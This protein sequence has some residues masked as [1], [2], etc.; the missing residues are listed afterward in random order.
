MNHTIQRTIGGL[1]LIGSRS[2]SAIKGHVL[3][4]I[5]V[6]QKKSTDKKVVLYRRKRKIPLLP[7]L[8]NV[9]HTT[10]DERQH[11]LCMTQL[12]QKLEKIKAQY[13]RVLNRKPKPHKFGVGYPVPYT[14]IGRARTR[15]DDEETVDEYW[16]GKGMNSLIL[17]S[18]A[19][20]I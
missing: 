1:V 8:N 13:Q 10:L 14:P 18:I 9:V 2:F 16:Y 4:S 5:M 3:Y 20:I 19:S 7:G 17:P 12:L 15:L 6:Y 11:Q